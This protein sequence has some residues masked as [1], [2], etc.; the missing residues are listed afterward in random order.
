M[1]AERKNIKLTG[2]TIHLNHNRREL[3]DISG[4][5]TKD[6]RMDE[7][8]SQIHVDGDLDDTQRKRL[9]AIATRCW[10]HRA[11]SPGIKIRTHAI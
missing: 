4:G 8:Q 1:Y 3:E 10:M 7:I 2:I 5:K 9:L 11:L 6:D